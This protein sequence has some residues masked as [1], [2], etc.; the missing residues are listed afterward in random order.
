MYIYDDNYSASDT[1]P[2]WKFNFAGKKI[3]TEILSTK[4]AFDFQILLM[5]NWFFEMYKLRIKIIYPRGKGPTQELHNFQVLARLI[6]FLFQLRCDQ[7]RSD[8]ICLNDQSLKIIH[9]NFEFLFSETFQSV[10][11]IRTLVFFSVYS[12]LG[13]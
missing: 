11:R 4:Q 3:I 8:V 13:S 6:N 12:I 5:K 10:L 2:C 9:D 7:R 1:K